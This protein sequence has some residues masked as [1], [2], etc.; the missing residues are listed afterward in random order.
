MCVHI[1]VCAGITCAIHVYLDKCVHT[2]IRAYTQTPPGQG[3]KKRGKCVSVYPHTTTGNEMWTRK[4]TPLCGGVWVCLGVCV[5]VF[6]G[7]WCVF[8]GVYV[9]VGVYTHVCVWGYI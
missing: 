5:C 2:I 9:W 1:Y 4:H 7:G 6:G 3:E 8:W